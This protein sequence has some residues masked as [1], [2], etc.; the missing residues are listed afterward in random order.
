MIIVQRR[1]RRDSLVSAVI[2]NHKSQINLYKYVYIN[3]YINICVHMFVY[4]HIY[5]L[6]PF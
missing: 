4:V 2:R 6:N 3:V 1:L 5:V